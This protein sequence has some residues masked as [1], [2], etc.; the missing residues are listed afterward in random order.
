M[1]LREQA[2][3]DIEQ[4]T[5][6]ADEWGI[7]IVLTAPDPGNETVTITGLH[8]KHY[9]SIDTDGNFVN[10]KN[11]QITFSEKFLTDAAYPVRNANNEVVLKGHK[12]DVKDSTGVL[13]HYVIREWFPDET[14]GLIRCILG[15][16]E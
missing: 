10:A 15:D 6:N 12:A 1:G 5:S 3:A 7:E 9:I 16:F 13:R 11:A 8:V 2:K 14:I 4:I